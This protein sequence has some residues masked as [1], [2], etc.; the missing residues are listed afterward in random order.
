MARGIKRV[1]LYG[2]LLAAGAALGMQLVS[3]TGNPSGSSFGS[4]SASI[5]Q[6][7]QAGQT[8]SVSGLAGGA[9]DGASTLA[10]SQGTAAPLPSGQG[11]RTAGAVYEQGTYVKLPDGTTYYYVQTPGTGSSSLPASSTQQQIAVNSPE[12]DGSGNTAGTTLYQS[13]GQL[14][15]AAPQTS[16]DRFADKTGQLL[17]NASQKSIDWV[18]SLFGS[19]TD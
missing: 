11:G 2:G 1:L 7:A 10:A 4:Y 16:I 19:L 15:S 17:Q 14:L 3:G 5:T 9:A 12:A 18:V 13:P 8:G 6:G